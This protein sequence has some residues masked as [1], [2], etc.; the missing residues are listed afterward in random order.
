MKLK[1]DMKNNEEQLL[2]VSNK[3]QSILLNL[4]NNASSEVPIGKDENFNN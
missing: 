3:L 2:K 1:K 4:P